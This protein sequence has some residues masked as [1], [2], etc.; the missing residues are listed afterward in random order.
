LKM[1]SLSGKG[2]ADIH[3][4]RVVASLQVGNTRIHLSKWFVCE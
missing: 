3:L 1:F 4:S 2:R